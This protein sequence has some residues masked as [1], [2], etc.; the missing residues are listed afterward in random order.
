MFNVYVALVASA[1][2]YLFG[3][4]EIPTAPF[5][6]AL[7]L[8]SMLEANF[9]AAYTITFGKIWTVFQRPMFLFIFIVAVLTLFAPVIKEAIKKIKT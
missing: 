9:W 4:A 6:L 8:G 5:L 2:A 1:V 7:V 3:K